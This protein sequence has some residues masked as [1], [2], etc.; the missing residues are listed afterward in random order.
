[1]HG[2]G[3]S[4]MSIYEKGYPNLTF[5]ISNLGIFDTD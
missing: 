4:A 2:A 1:M 5:V 3:G